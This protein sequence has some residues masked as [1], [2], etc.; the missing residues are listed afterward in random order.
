VGLEFLG[1][2]CAGPG[3]MRQDAQP[4]R[5][6]AG[7]STSTPTPAPAR[8]AKAS[9]LVWKLGPPRRPEAPAVTEH[10]WLSGCY[11]PITSNVSHADM[12]VMAPV[13]ALNVGTPQFA[14]A[15][16]AEML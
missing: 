2:G 14:E 10:H 13:A 5:S 3:R 8:H 4:S 16:V 12:R 1:F 7:V 15:P 6:L 9:S 11:L